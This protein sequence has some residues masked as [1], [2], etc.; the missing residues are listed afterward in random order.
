MFTPIALALGGF[1][2]V[3]FALAFWASGRIETEEDFIVAGR[4][5]PGWVSFST[6]LATW[7]GAA[8]LQCLFSVG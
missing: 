5:M 8:S 1:S 4:S 7:F 2:A 3:L 6:L